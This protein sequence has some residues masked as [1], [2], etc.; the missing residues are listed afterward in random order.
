[1]ASGAHHSTP[2]T[3][4]LFPSPEEETGTASDF[5]SAFP[6]CGHNLEL[7][8]ADCCTRPSQV[9][10]PPASHLLPT[11]LQL[12]QNH[13]LTS[14]PLHSDSVPHCIALPAH[15]PPHVEFSS[16]TITALVNPASCLEEVSTMQLG[17]L[18]GTVVPD[19]LGTSALWLHC[20]HL[21]PLAPDFSLPATRSLAQGLPSQ[22]WEQQ[23]LEDPCLARATPPTLPAVLCCP[24]PTTA[25]APPGA[26]P[27]L[28][29]SHL[30]SA[31][32]L[33]A[34]SLFCSL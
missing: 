29:L 17:V 2:S 25:H 32:S 16:S 11:A 19:A 20:Y 18:G 15:P 28:C 9:L 6:F 27:T 21:H 1:M 13:G 31:P 26:S 14:S 33:Q 4:L 12:T 24:L 30:K 22:L 7:V 8:T 34:L 23:Q 5:R 10:E 3:V